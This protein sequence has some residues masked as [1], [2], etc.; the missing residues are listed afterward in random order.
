[1]RRKEKPG[2]GDA[3]LALIWLVSGRERERYA[4]V[5][6]DSVMF[7]FCSLLNIMFVFSWFPSSSLP[8]F[9]VSYAQFKKKNAVSRWL[10]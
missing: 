4:H 6:Y 8:D 3:H 10:I 9:K 7:M 1:M 2:C 5:L